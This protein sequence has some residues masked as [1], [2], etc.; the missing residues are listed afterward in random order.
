VAHSGPISNISW[1]PRF[2][3]FC[4]WFATSSENTI[5]VW[6]LELGDLDT[7]TVLQVGSECNVGSDQ[8]GRITKQVT[9]E[10]DEM[11]SRIDWNRF[12]SLLAAIDISGQVQVWQITANGQ[13][14]NVLQFLE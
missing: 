13:A 4:Q 3:K 14:F 1:S 12:G 8:L 11:V 5:S 10:T 7:Q 9:V 2:G 6:T